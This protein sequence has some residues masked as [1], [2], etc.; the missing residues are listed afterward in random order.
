MRRQDIEVDLQPRRVSAVDDD[1]N[2]LA[3]GGLT[4]SRNPDRVLDLGVLEAGSAHDP[5]D[6]AGHAGI[7]R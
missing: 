3:A 6:P 4:V 2:A 1:G 7:I 5:P